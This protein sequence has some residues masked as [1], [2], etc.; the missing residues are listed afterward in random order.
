[1]VQPPA[2]GLRDRAANGCPR[3]ARANL[4]I[5]VDAHDLAN[6]VLT[7]G[8]A[9]AGTEH[10]QRTHHSHNWPR[11]TKTPGTRRT[12]ARETYQLLRLAAPL[13]LLRSAW[14]ATAVARSSSPAR[15]AR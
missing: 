1:M 4:V 3:Q 13:T 15:A 5:T 8:V 10:H 12:W 2:G 14:R 11:A 6:H 9:R 7:N